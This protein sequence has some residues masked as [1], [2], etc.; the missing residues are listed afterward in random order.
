[1]ELIEE[2]ISNDTDSNTIDKRNVTKNINDVKSITT[3][4]IDSNHD[5][6]AVTD[7]ELIQIKES[8]TGFW[9]NVFY[10]AFSVFITSLIVVIIHAEKS[11]N[12]REYLVYSSVVVGSI[13]AL[14]LSGI[15]W[16]RGYNSSE[17]IIKRIRK[18]NKYV[19]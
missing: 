2:I 1:M 5:Y 8:S 17:K 15:A 13:I 9:Q 12:T 14:L 7:E 19:I 3:I 6:Y 16:Y 18:R 10:S 11:S 4:H